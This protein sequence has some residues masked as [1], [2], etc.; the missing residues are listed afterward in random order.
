[1]SASTTLTPEVLWAQRANLVYITVNLPDATPTINLTEDKLEV[2]ATSDGKNYAVS[3]DFNQAINPETSVTKPSAR[4][5]FF[6]L[7]KKK[8]EWWPRLN[9]GSKKL[10]F[11]KTDF[12]RWKDEDDEDDEAEQADG[13]D[14]GMG[15]MGGMGGGMGGMGGGMGGMGGMG[16]MDF[17]KLMASMG[18][19]GQGG[20]PS[21]GDYDDEQEDDS[22]D[23]AEEEEIPALETTEK[24]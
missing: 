9:K 12:S 13:M 6:T 24:H 15:G 18:Q 7:M 21:M 3:I 2:T 4:N 1:M 16:D 19:G 17:Q 14:M 11:V 5:I 10:N 23:E 20:M 22:G 8:E